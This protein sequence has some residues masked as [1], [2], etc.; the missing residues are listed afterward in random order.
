MATISLKPL[1]I[2]NVM[3]PTTI[4]KTNVQMGVNFLNVEMESSINNQ[5]S[6]MTATI[7]MGIPAII[8]VFGQHVGMGNN[9]RDNNATM[10]IKITLMHVPMSVSWQF[11]AMGFPKLNKTKSVM[12]ETAIIKIH[13]QI[14]A[15]MQPV[16]MGLSLWGRSNAMII[17]V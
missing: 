11:V 14:N 13:V 17:T 10:E 16:G 7:T 6:V 4:M 3:M 8:P 5:N 15:K 2:N 12:M 9:N 1:I